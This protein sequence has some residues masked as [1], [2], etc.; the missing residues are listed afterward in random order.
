MSQEYQKGFFKTKSKDMKQIGKKFLRIA[1]GFFF[2]KHN[3]RLSGNLAK[4][5]YKC[6]F[7]ET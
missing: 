4:S 5:Y 3:Q 2:L 1:K 7:F 6:F